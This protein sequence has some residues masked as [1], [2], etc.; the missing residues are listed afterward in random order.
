MLPRSPGVHLIGALLLSAV[1]ARSGTAAKP[2]R[3]TWRNVREPDCDSYDLDVAPFALLEARTDS[4]QRVDVADED[5]GPDA[6]GLQRARS[7]AA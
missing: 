1:S 2:G 6:G 7:R 5:R 3:F 4:R